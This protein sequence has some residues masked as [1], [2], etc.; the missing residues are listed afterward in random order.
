MEQRSLDVLDKELG[1]TML[2]NDHNGP[3]MVHITKLYP[4]QDATKFH[5]FENVISGTCE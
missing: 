2:S 5:A 1:E 4:T 3:L